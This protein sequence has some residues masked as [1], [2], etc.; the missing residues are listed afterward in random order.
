V[1]L[2]TEDA[3][4]EE[5]CNLLKADTIRFAKVFNIQ[6]SEREELTLGG[7]FCPGM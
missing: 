7:F 2:A 4:Y 3:Q 5:V 6:A 1:A